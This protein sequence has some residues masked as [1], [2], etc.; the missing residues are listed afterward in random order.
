[1]QHFVERD[2]KRVL[3]SQHGLGQRV[4]DQN[5]VDP[6]LSDQARGGLVVR[7]ETSY[8]FVVEFLFAERS[9]GNLA[10]RFA[11]RNQT[12]D[13]LQCPSATQRIEPV[14]ILDATKAIVA[15]NSPPVEL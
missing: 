8:R 10:A 3:V 13:V 4:A 1:V 15:A 5:N 9:D 14:P 7:G 11:D 6:G 12:H 2:R